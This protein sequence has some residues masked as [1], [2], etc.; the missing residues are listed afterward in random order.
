MVRQVADTEPTTAS[1]SCRSRPS[2][3]AW[4]SWTGPSLCSPVH[5]RGAD[6]GEGE[7]REPSTRR[8]QGCEA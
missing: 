4:T 3:A 5:K 1:I 7:I 8:D 6:G 2:S